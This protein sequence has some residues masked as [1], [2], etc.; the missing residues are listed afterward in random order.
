MLS[1]DFTAFFK[2]RDCFFNP[3]KLDV[4]P[5]SGSPSNLFGILGTP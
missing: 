1:K 3:I 4:I 5:Q 2:L